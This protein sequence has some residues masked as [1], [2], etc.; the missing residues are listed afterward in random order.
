MSDPSPRTDLGSTLADTTQFDQRS[1]F[2]QLEFVLEAAGIGAWEWDLIDDRVIASEAS[3]QVIGYALSDIDPIAPSWWLQ[4]IHPEDL[5]GSLASLRCVFKRTSDSFSHEMRVQHRDGHWVWVLETGAVVA[6]DQDGRA[7]RLVGTLLNITDLK[8]STERLERQQKM[9]QMMSRQGRIGAWEFD[10]RKQHIF[11]SSMTKEIH[12]V[13]EN[14]QPQ[15]DT[16]IE[17]YKEGDHR[18]QIVAAVEKGIAEGKPWFAE[19]KIIT[20]KGNERWVAA[21]GSPELEDGECVR[22]YGSFQDIDYRKKTETALLKAKEEAEAAAKAKSEFLAIMSHEIRT[23]LNGVMGMLGLLQR[24]DLSNQQLRKAQIAQ[25][26]AE[27]LLGIVTDILDFSKVDAGHLD[28]LET[29]FNLFNLVDD[30]IEDFAIRAQD[31]NIELVLDQHLVACPILI[32]DEGRLRQ[33]LVNLVGNAV[34]FTESGEVKVT[35]RLEAKPDRNILEVAVQDTGIGVSAEKLQDLF[36]PF[37]QADASTTRKYGGTGLGLAICKKLCELMG[38]N[39]SGVSEEEKGSTFSFFVPTK[40]GKNAA[41]WHET[42]LHGK[43]I[44]VVEPHPSSLATIVCQLHHW[45]A[46][47]T[48]AEDVE[49][50]FESADKMANKQFSLILVAEQLSTGGAEQAAEKF[51]SHRLLQGTP[52]VLMNP[53]NDRFSEGG[54]LERFGY[55]ASLPKPITHADLAAAI[56]FIDDSLADPQETTLDQASQQM[57]EKILL[58]EDNAINQEVALMLLEDIGRTA[59]VAENGAHALELLQ[60]APQD[61]PFSLIFMDCQMPVLDGYQATAKIRGGEAGKRYINIPIIAMTANAMKGDRER[62]LAAGMVDYI[63]KPIE[64]DVLQAHIERWSGEP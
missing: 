15:L 60:E 16:A 10:L 33:I 18:D 43:R 62:C 4:R 37:T 25:S 3:A 13:D 32:G 63:S 17:F 50:A 58:V 55:L 64:D 5:Q 31:K 27:S 23:P 57:A 46:E 30:V 61:A 48:A 12:E 53:M 49:Q 40:L 21:T 41:D 36:N 44:L 51:L 52:L 54:E 29:E 22:I 8:E 1:R 14:F 39:I 7:T 42:N 47:V 34:K 2:S 11:W 38:G 9:F 59:T 28:L 26:S 45:G 20:A 35:V 6:W 24:S 56:E 19:A